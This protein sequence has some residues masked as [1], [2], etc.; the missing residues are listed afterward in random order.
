MSFPDGVT[1]LGRISSHWLQWNRAPCQVTA[2]VGDMAEFCLG[3][4]H[5]LEAQMD[6]VFHPQAVAGFQAGWNGSR[7]LSPSLLSAP[8]RE[9][10]S[11]RLSCAMLSPAMCSVRA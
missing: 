8:N 11:G 1:G 2:E 6:G 10:E 9:L 3:M 4:Q 7:R 5:G